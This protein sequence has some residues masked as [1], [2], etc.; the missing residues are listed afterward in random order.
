MLKKQDII[1]K[2]NKLKPIY[3]KEGVLL[4]GFFGSYA[5]DNANNKSDIDLLY[6]IEPKQFM[7]YHKGFS[8]FS[9]ILDIKYELENEFNTTIDLC[10]INNL[11]ETFKQF[12]LKDVIYV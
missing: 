1:N 7:K 12:A 4:L 9:R 3:Q 8:G 2:I 11:N 10:A 5:K 6:K